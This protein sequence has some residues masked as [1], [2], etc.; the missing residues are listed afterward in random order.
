M[1]LEGLF[2]RR[3]EDGPSGHEPRYVFVVTYGRSGSTL[4]QDAALL[5]GVREGR[6]RFLEKP[7]TPGQ[8]TAAVRQ[9]LDSEQHE[10]RH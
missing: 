2:N 10:I 5:E 7:F 9:A 3:R 6:A 1:K 4:T 8:L